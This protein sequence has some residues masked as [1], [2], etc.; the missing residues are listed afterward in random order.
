MTYFLVCIFLNFYSFSYRS[1]R[2]PLN[3][4]WSVQWRPELQAQIVNWSKINSNDGDK[5]S[6]RGI[7]RS[8]VW[9]LM[10]TQH[11]FFVPRSWQDLKTS[12][13]S[14]L[15]FNTA[16]KIYHFS[17]VF[18]NDNYKITNLVKNILVSFASLKFFIPGY[19]HTVFDNVLKIGKRETSFQ[20]IP[21]IFIQEL[22]SL[23][24][25]DDLFSDLKSQ[26][27]PEGV[28]LNETT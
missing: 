21:T 4:G 3:L 17:S 12:L 13:I 8:E 1:K 22:F 16:Q 19:F 5:A 10:R 23:N 14:G 26:L 24:D 11:F 7:W 2:H 25:K 15:Y 27:E 28:S 6:E 9:F 20:Y 18:N